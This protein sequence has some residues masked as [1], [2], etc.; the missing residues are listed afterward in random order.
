M[1]IMQLT[2]QQV[3]KVITESILRKSI[4]TL[5]DILDSLLESNNDAVLLQINKVLSSPANLSLIIR[6]ILGDS[7]AFRKVGK[8]SYYHEN[9]FHKIVI[10]SG[11]NFKL[12]LHHFGAQAKIPMENIHDHRWAFA[13]S[14]LTGSLKMDLFKADDNEGE[15]LIHYQYNSIKTNGKYSTDVIGSAKLKVIETKEFIAGQQYLMTC[16]DLH[17]IL[18]KAGE[19]SM[20]LILTGKPENVT[21]NLYA[22]K[23]IEDNEKS[24]IPY[25]KKQLKRMLVQISE[26]IFPI[27]N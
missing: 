23:A 7:A 21:C 24:T 6:K 3:Q 13:S 25:E 9:G 2:N 5:K 17:R 8:E 18:N 22:R 14:I 10:L 26:K 4:N 12:R 15:Q 11:K 1:K 27:L 20:T 19:E 16:E